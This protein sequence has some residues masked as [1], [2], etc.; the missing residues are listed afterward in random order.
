MPSDR[1]PHS[2]TSPD[3]KSTDGGRISPAAIVDSIRTAPVPVVNTQYLAD[4]HDVSVD[5]MF[6]Q[7]SAMVEVGTLKHHRVEDRWHLW[8]L[9]LE[10]ELDN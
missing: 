10:T 1:Y 8:W 5:K 9:P 4:E 2:E 6:E 7:L 3:P